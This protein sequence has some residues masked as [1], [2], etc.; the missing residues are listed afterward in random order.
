MVV[1]NLVTQNSVVQPIQL[2]AN[3]SGAFIKLAANGIADPSVDEVK[4]NSL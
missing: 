1:Y 4:V 3:F 2:Q